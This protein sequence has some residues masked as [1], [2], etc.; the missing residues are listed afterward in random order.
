MDKVDERYKCPHCGET[1]ADNLVWEEDGWL[2][3]AMCDG[4]YQL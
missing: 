1:H 3:C 2:V 4:V